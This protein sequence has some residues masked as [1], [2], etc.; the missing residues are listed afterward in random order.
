MPLIAYRP[1][2]EMLRLVEA[3]GGHWTGYRALCRC[4]AHDDKTPS[5]SIRQ[6]DRGI[7]VK[8]FA[9]CANADILRELSRIARVP[10]VGAPNRRDHDHPPQANVRRLWNEG[11]DVTATLA[12]RYLERRQIEPGFHGLR[13]HPR[14]PKGPKPATV[15][16]PALLVAAYE[17]DELRAL[18][19]I[20]LRPDGTAIEKLMIGHPNAA[21]W[22]GSQPIDNT[23]GIAEGFESAARFT[24]RT[25]I[26]CWASLGAAR[27]P[28][29][30]LPETLER[31][32]IA[33]DDDAEGRAAAVRAIQGYGRT[34]LT[35]TR[36][37][38]PRPPGLRGPNDWA[39]LD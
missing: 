5:L 1:S 33:E 16:A 20:F 14:C 12:A 24:I 30:A 3:L 32:V 7:L 27:L 36:M 10:S 17:H 4:P 38:P 11:I 9:G 22:H 26:P 15:F 39:R 29:I 2:I 18:Q 28:L 31:L 23:L 6:G 8:C 21:S 35:I 34:G 19:R 37:P 13:Y 25:G